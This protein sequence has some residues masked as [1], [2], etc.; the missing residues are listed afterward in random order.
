MKGWLYIKFTSGN[1]AVGL[2]KHPTIFGKDLTIGFS[3]A[4]FDY[5]FIRNEAILNF[6]TGLFIS[7]A[8]GIFTFDIAVVNGSENMD[9]NSSKGGMARIGLKGKNWDFGISAKA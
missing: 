5:P 2:G 4:F 8:P 9:T 3:N 7:Y 1:F 6:E